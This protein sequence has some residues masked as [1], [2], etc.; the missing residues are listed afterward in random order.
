M[1][2]HAPA[3]LLEPA[4]VPAVADLSVVIVSWNTRELLLRCLAALDAAAGGLRVEAIVVDNGST[5]GTPEAVQACFTEVQLIALGANP[6]FAAANNRGLA[7]AGGRTICLLNPDTEPR[8]GALRALVDYLDR[9]PDVG[10]VGPRLL[11]PDGSEQAVG[12]RFPTLAQ[13]FLD[14]FPF[15]GRLA[16]SRLNGR[17][18]R[19]PRDRAFPIDFP[20]GACMAVRR[21][22]LDTTGP[23]DEGFFIYSEEVDW[24]R[25]LRDDGWRVVCLPTSEIVHH[26]GQSTGQQPGRMFVELHRSRRRYYRRR[27]GPAFVLAAQL[28]TRIGVLKETIVAWRRLRRGEL[29]RAQWRDRVRACGEVFRL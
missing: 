18:P 17:Y 3:T 8:P 2:Q 15:G 27:H 21:A 28:L 5:D 9:H 16:G 14:F 20:L 11:N 24:C 6:G 13:V 1:E 7:A 19:A 25:R 29:T 22:V 26:G 12:F 23:L 4:V 10:M